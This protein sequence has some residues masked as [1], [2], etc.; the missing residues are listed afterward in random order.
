MFVIASDLD[1]PVVKNLSSESLSNNLR[2]F[3][4]IGFKNE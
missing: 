2:M 3:I 1:E 4:T